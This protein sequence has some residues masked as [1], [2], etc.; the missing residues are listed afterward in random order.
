MSKIYLVKTAYDKNDLPDLKD[1][2][3]NFD[4]LTENIKNRKII[5][6]NAI[7][8]GGIAET[9]GKM[10]FGNKKGININFDGIN[11][12]ELFKVNYGAFIIETEEDMNYKNAALIGNVTDNNSEN[13]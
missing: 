13:S 7:K 2:K 11:A 8:G 12:D 9:I 1:L 10:T 4:F 6:A 3:E 5:S